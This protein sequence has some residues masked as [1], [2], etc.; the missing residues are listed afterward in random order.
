[1]KKK[2]K[3]VRLPERFQERKK[4]TQGARTIFE[5]LWEIT[6]E[7]YDTSDVLKNDLRKPCSPLHELLQATPK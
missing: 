2:E 5:E 3:P 1:M 4:T 7:L 6:S